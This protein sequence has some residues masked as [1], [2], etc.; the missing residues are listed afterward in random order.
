MALEPETPD[1]SLKPGEIQ[2]QKPDPSP[3][4][5]DDKK[6]EPKKNGGTIY[7]DLGID[8]P[9]KE[10]STSWAATWRED[11]A[12]G[13][14][15]KPNDKHLAALKRFDTP[16]ALAKS[17]LAAVE[18]LRSGEYKKVGE[19][20]PADADPKIVAAWRE[21]QGL[22]KE[23]TEF[24][25]QAPD[26]KLEELNEADRGHIGTIQKMFFD[27]KLTKAQG[28]GLAQQF[29][30]LTEE[31]KEAEANT[32]ANNMDAI[33]DTLRADWGADYRN[34]MKMNVAFMKQTFGDEWDNVNKAR[35]PNGMR[36]G[37]NPIW[38][39]FMN[40]QARAEGGDAF[41]RNDDNTGGKGI[42]AEIAE[43]EKIMETNMPLYLQKHEKRYGELL[44]MKEKK[45]QLPD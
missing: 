33:E 21:E 27:T 6:P 1:P 29:L 26:V 45:G 24:Q 19:A 32:D 16:K 42:D 37:D 15:G 34:N 18:K 3:K 20:P 40:A 44:A 30:K 28:D 25:I 35:M 14:D 9:G 4:L 43:I 11:L 17:Y 39:K 10:G 13:D 7:D 2:N 8:E 41:V 23:P 38:A 5:E 22:P 36:L 31:V 12:A